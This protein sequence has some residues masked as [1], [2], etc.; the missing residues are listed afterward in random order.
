[1]EPN[2]TLLEIAPAEALEKY[3][4][5][6]ENEVSEQTLQAHKYR[7][8]HFIRW[9]NLNDIEA[10]SDLSPKDLQD[11]RYWRQQDGDLNTVTLH[12][13]MTTFRVFLQWA[14]DYQA[15]PNGFHNRVRI[16]TLERDQAAKDTKVKPERVK[17]I[18]EY[19]EKYEYAT[20]K[21]TMLS[22]MWNTGIRIG[23]VRGLDLQDFHPRDEYIEVRH[24]PQQETPLKNKNQGQRPISLDAK[25]C[26]IIEH[27]IEARRHDVTDEYGREPLFTTTHGRPAV[28]TLRERVYQLARPCTYRDGFCPHDKDPKTCEAANRSD[29]ASKCPSSF[30]PH[31]IRRSSITYWLLEDVPEEA[32]SDRM[33]VNKDVIDQHYD[34]RTPNEKM[35]QRRDYFK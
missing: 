16:P 25:R 6:R 12:T 19:L 11:Y 21:H 1:M 22:L 32:V 8:N 33:N 15:L 30:S 7:L 29:V 14:E 31:T 9:C 10:L 35:E 23:A 28:S 24:R 17:Q 26:Q 34:K 18:L 27:F 2:T 13:Q 20:Q 3:L 4:M 5:H